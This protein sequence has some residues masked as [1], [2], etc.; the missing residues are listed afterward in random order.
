MVGKGDLR[1]NSSMASNQA[2]NQMQINKVL[3]VD[4]DL[5]ISKVA[6]V[7]LQKV[8]KWEVNVTYRPRRAQVS[9]VI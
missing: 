1:I 2:G 5:A 9:P 3:L 4:D 6:A 7:C 8:G